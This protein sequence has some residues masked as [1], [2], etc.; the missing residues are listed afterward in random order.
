MG[1]NKSTPKAFTS[2]SGEYKSDKY[3]IEQIIDYIA[4]DYILT[5]NFQDMK[6]LAD[7]K[8]CNE[9]SI[10]T[11]DI[12]QQ[13]LNNQ[14]ILYLA[15]RFKDGMEIDEER[16]DNVIFFYKKNIPILD[17]S[18]QT[19]KVKICNSIAKFY[20]KIAHLFASIISTINPT[21]IYKNANGEM[22]ALGLLQK[23]EIPENAEVSIKNFNLCSLRINSLINNYNYNVSPDTEIGIKPQFCTINY[24]D[25]NN[26][27]LTLGDEPGIPELQSLYFD[28][29]NYDK[30]IFGGD[31]NMQNNMS[32]EMFI[33]YKKD[34]N[35]FYTI[36]TG[37]KDIPSTDTINKFSD[38]SLKK[39]H[40]IDNCRENGLFT[41]EVRGTL[42]DKLFNQYATH[43]KN[44][45]DNAEQ[46]KKQ[47]LDIIDTLF[48]FSL[49]KNTNTKRVVINPMLN[50]NTLQKLIDN[51]RK[52]IIQLYVKCE[53][54]YTIGLHIFEAI[55]ENQILQTTIKQID[56]LK[57]SSNNLLANTPVNPTNTNPFANPTIN[58]TN[59]NPFANPTINP[60][61]NPTTNHITNTIINPTTNTNI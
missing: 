25:K 9:L 11:S 55:V 60:F 32:P 45:L 59:T 19:E 29:Y 49:D 18:N 33:E 52:I 13:N 3:S 35:T 10:L 53:E 41:Q 27:D 16:N 36:F 56:N 6:N 17:I 50:D 42:K 4:T 14:E 24:D 51:T 61:A 5:Q 39:Y 47:L 54:D 12:I 48:V 15:K 34:L 1:N 22:K 31:D 7:L 46:N 23:N 40:N 26:K 20:I 21:Y 37:N 44:M 43:I 38:I 28:I 57:N 30:G 58:P 8:Y 2:T